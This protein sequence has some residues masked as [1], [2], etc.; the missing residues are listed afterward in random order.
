MC[1]DVSE[2]HITSIFRIENQ[3]EQDTSLQQ[4]TTLLIFDT[5]DGGDMFLQNVGSHTDCTV[6]N[7]RKLQYS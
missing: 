4:V 2:E 1:T 6:L 7:P 3:A 5:E